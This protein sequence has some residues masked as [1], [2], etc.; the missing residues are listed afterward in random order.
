MGL[1]LLIEEHT[2]IFLASSII[3]R[4]ESNSIHYQEVQLTALTLF[5]A[6]KPLVRITSSFVF[7]PMITAMAM[8]V[9]S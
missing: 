7:Q 1:L 4:Y 9:Q 6:K 3:S 5:F 8:Q 2:L